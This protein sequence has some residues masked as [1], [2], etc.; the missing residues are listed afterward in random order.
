MGRVN[1]KRFYE[2]FRFMPLTDGPMRRFLP[3]GHAA[4]R[5]PKR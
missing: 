4:L 2:S 1:A 3:P 5:G